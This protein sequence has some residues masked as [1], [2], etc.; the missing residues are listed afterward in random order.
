M[1]SRNFRLCIVSRPGLEA[2]SKDGGLSEKSAELYSK[3]YPK[4]NVLEL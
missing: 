3:E 2:N 4:Y 1:P